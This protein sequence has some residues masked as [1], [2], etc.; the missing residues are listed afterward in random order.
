VRFDTGHDGLANKGDGPLRGFEIA[1]ADGEYRFAN[2]MIDNDT[3]VVRNDAIPQPQTVRYA[4]EGMPDA[5]LVNHSG[6]P[7]APFRTDAQGCINAEVQKQQVTRR[8]ATSSYEV[9]IDPNGKV[10]SL[11]CGGV[12]FLSNESG[13][14]GGS[15]IPGFWGSRPLTHIQE[16]GPRLLAFSDDTVSLRMA[17]EEKS[18]KWSVVNSGKDAVQFQLALSSLVNV[19][20]AIDHGK[21]TV[22]R[23]AVNLTLDGFDAITNTPTGPLL[24]ATVNG[25]ATK[26]LSLK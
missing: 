17:F 19:P 16:L 2:A 22:R 18:M 20:P 11:T 26:S 21:A 3:V 25:G 5:S 10:V 15:S 7:A 9:V 23:G 24:T 12:Q 8:V 4:W 14:V 6:L 13:A 1:G